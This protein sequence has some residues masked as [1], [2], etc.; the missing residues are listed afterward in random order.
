M[1]ASDEPAE[2]REARRRRR[3]LAAAIST[4]GVA[5]AVLHLAWPDLEI[6]AVTLAFLVVA[7]VPWLAPIFKTIELPGGWRF[8]YQEFKREV[9][10]ELATKG[11]QVQTLANRLE[12]VERLVV[13]GEATPGQAEDL[14]QVVSDFRAYLRT[15]DEGLELP[16]PTVRVQRGLDNSYYDGARDEIVLDSAFAADPYAVLREYGHHVLTETRAMPDEWLESPDWDIESGLADYLAASFTGNPKI[17]EV[18]A[19]HLRES[20]RFDRPFIRELDNDRSFPDIAPEEPYQGAG[21]VWGGAFWD[22]REAIGREDAD[23]VVVAAWL[24]GGSF[25]AGRRAG[26]FAARVVDAVPADRRDEARRAFE[27]RG[28][29]LPRTRS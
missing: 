27:A 24:G 14:A 25:G 28:L 15:V 29:V 12:D 19:A 23:R 18:I 11:E 5:L 16:L 6:D 21:E 2:S 17:G 3:L 1:E 10:Q 13:S 4:A 26:D 7:A 9:R 22:L 8:E 20:G